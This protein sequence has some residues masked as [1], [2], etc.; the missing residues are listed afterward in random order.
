MVKYGERSVVIRG[1]SS[2]EFIRKCQEYVI[3]SYEQKEADFH[4]YRSM[5]HFLSGCIF[6]NIVEVEQGCREFFTSKPKE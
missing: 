4:I 5:A 2:F 1:A 3:M 6:Q